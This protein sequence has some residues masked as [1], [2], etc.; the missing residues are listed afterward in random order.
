MK[1]IKSNKRHYS[2]RTPINL[3][4]DRSILN[5]DSSFN[6]RQRCWC[7]RYTA[8]PREETAQFLLQLGE[9]CNDSVTFG[10]NRFACVRNLVINFA[11]YL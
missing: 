10:A 3:V 11:V 1:E 9:N 6:W 2:C 8:T 7:S 4:R 5:N